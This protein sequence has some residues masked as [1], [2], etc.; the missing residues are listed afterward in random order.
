MGNWY[1]VKHPGLARQEEVGLGLGAPIWTARAHLDQ[2]SDGTLAGLSQLV[3][4]NAVCRT[5]MRPEEPRQPEGDP[6]TPDAAGRGGDNPKYI[7]VEPMVGYRMAEG[8]SE[9]RE[10]E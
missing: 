7:F 3:L 10:T 2:D 5:D 9:R 4:P 1:W 6:H 8:K